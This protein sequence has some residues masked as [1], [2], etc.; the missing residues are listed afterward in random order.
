MK[1]II[2]GILGC[3]IAVCTIVS[4]LGIYS[5]SSRKNEMENCVSQILVRNLNRYY[6][7]ELGD[8]EVAAIV[9]QEILEQLHAK[10][11]VAV[12]IRACNMDE[13][14]LSVRVTEQFMLPGGKKKSISCEKTILVDRIEEIETEKIEETEEIS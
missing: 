3:M 13:G 10:S 7:T 2:V 5:I 11:Q 9:R 14:L 1:N 6:G 4:C 8:A 12:E